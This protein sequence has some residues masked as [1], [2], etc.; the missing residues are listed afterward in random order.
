MSREQVKNHRRAC[1]Q[2]PFLFKAEL[3]FFHILEIV[4]RWPGSLPLIRRSQYSLA[5][6]FTCRRSRLLK[7]GFLRQ[8]RELKIRRKNQGSALHIGEALLSVNA[9]RR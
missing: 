1:T 9:F 4:T 2:V 6:T 3:G 5:G 8:V 7:T